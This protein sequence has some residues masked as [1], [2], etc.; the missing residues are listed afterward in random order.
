MRIAPIQ[1]YSDR[2]QDA[3]TRSVAVRKTRAA[4]R[5]SRSDPELQVQ[6]RT[7]ADPLEFDSHKGSIIDIRV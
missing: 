7:P 2:I 1:V 6:A 3:V 4:A 5:A